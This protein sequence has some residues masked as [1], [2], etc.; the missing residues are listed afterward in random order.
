LNRDHRTTLILVTHDMQLA[1][2][3]MR[4]AEL[5]EGRL[6]PMGAQAA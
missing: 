4:R 2:R 3:C 1:E 5:Q 6:H